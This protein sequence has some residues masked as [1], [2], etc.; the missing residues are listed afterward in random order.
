MATPGR[1]SERDPKSLTHIVAIDAAAEPAAAKPPVVPPPLPPLRGLSRSKGN[2]G[3]HTPVIP[4]QPPALQQWSECSIAATNFPSPGAERTMTV[5][6]NTGGH[7]QMEPDKPTPRSVPT[8]QADIGKYRLLEVI[9][10]GGMGIVYRAEHKILKRVVALK[11]M[12]PS[13]AE[14]Q[15]A[16]K[17]FLT[18]ARAAAALKD[19][20]IA[21][22]YDFSEIDGQFCLE[23]EL[24]SGEPLE[25]RL[26]R[27][28]VPLRFALWVI[29][30]VALGLGV[31]HQAGFIHRD[32]KPANLWL[33]TVAGAR[34]ESDPFEKLRPDDDLSTKEFSLYLRVKILDFGLVRLEQDPG[35]WRKRNSIVGTPAYMA[36]E[37]AAGQTADARSDLFSLGVVF[38]RMLTG[39]LPFEGETPMEILTAVASDVAPPVTKFNPEV[40]LPVASLVQQLLCRNPNDRLQ[41]AN[42][43]VE[44]V[45]EIE[46]ELFDP[47][48]T[49]APRKSNSLTWLIPIALVVTAAAGLLGWYW[50]NDRNS[51]AQEVPSIQASRPDVTVLTPD[52]ATKLVGDKITVEFVVGSIWRS[53]D[54]VLLYETAPKPNEPAFRLAL[55]QRIVTTMQ[56]RGYRWPEVL[57]GTRLRVHGMVYREGSFAEILVS[58]LQQFDKIL[59][60]ERGEPK[61]TEP[62]PKDDAEQ[63]VGPTPDKPKAPDTK[64]GKDLS[65]S[66]EDA[67]KKILAPFMKK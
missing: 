23:M 60:P 32:I 49:V 44:A 38:F 47:P 37:Q 48:I 53:G 45:T 9:G 34:P 55:A 36:P 62:A 5:D 66:V 15:R 13:L 19:D 8:E 20:R 26:R 63:P 57:R 14:D 67:T 35:V 21:T 16:W 3:A 43:L 6:A 50:W 40:P 24:L 25:T 2:S 65:D 31:A 64:E 28:R 29:R 30:E 56:K 58:D 39:R 10:E 52:E 27:G 33:D 4:V 18:E 61:K 22:I 17:L 42:A 59:Y 41:S 1:P 54:Q 7:L 46:H 11:M 12:R 51:P